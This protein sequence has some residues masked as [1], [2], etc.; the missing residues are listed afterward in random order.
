MSIALGTVVA[1][2]ANG[3]VEFGVVWRRKERLKGGEEIVTLDV[4]IRP[5]PS[6]AADSAAHTREIERNEDEVHELSSWESSS[7]TKWAKD[8]AGFEWAEAESQRLKA[9]PKPPEAP[10]AEAPI[11]GK[12]KED[13]PF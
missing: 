12:P 6:I 9:R 10:A 1:I 7:F 13:V 2:E 4:L 11:P 5:V 8:H 3:A